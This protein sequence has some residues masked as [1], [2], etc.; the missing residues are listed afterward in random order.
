MLL[1]HAIGV[2][3]LQRAGSLPEAW[4]ASQFPVS[5]LIALEVTCRGDKGT[6]SPWRRA[7]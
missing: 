4:E 2:G 3:Y 7:W 5:V 6:R 1:G